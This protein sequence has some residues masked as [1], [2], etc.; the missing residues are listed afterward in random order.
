[1]P[2]AFHCRML[3]LLGVGVSLWSVSLTLAPRLLAGQDKV[4]LSPLAE[5][6]PL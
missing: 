5:G 2:S 1:M 4:R 6:R 3:M